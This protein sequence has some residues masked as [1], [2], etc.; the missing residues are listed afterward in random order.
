MHTCIVL[1][2]LVQFSL[3]F[4]EGKRKTIFRD[5]LLTWKSEKETFCFWMIIFFD[6]WCWNKRRLIVLALNSHV[7]YKFIS[8]R[9]TCFDYVSWC[10]PL[11]SNLTTRVKLV[12]REHAWLPLSHANKEVYFYFRR[13]IRALA[14]QQQ[15]SLTTARNIRSNSKPATVCCVYS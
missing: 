2:F 6:F 12:T 1:F 10:F 11:V 9:F 14:W 5:I 7:L 8:W 15:Q 3:H 13:S 4:R